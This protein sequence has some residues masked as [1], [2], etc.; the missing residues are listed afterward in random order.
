MAIKRLD[1]LDGWRG[2][3]ILFV[4]AAHL[5]PLGPSAL[6][7]NASSGL[8][9]MTLFF[10]LSGF[11]ITGHF[12]RGGGIL[13]FF[14][15]RFFRIIPLAW[16]GI[17]VAALWGVISP[18][19]LISHLFFYANWPPMTL[20]DVTAHYWSLCVEVQF[21]V[22][23]ALLF[24]VFGHRFFGPLLFFCLSVTLFRVYHG[25]HEAITT[26][27]RIDE[28]LAG[29]LLA[30]VYF[31]GDRWA[32]LARKALQSTPLV[33][34]IVA[35]FFASHSIGGWL[36][37]LRPYIA[38]ALVGATLV[39]PTSPVNGWLHNKLLIYIANI[40]FALYVIHPFF[41]HTWLGEGERIEKYLKRIPLF[42]LLWLLAHVSTFY[43]ENK[44]MQTGKWFSAR[45]SAVRRQ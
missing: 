19:A 2:L 24:A 30:F 38:A 33:F 40:S 7:L 16:L 39:R 12:L 9:G 14:I 43:F 11:L 32:E 5:L 28:I 17:F 23:V 22:G 18:D 15:R 31:G 27:F 4:L 21:Y 10:A 41:G 3:S 1:V 34:L 35:L 25:V 13:E 45:L 37:Y 6:K 42:L 20:S 8:I 26:Y 36:N 44:F 29:S